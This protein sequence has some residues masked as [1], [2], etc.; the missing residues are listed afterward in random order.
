[1]RNLEESVDGKALREHFGACGKIWCARVIYNKV[2]GQ[3]MGFGF[4]R[5]FSDEEA[6]EAVQRFNGIKLETLSSR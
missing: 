4:V 2:N 1:M 6:N 5:F 3:S